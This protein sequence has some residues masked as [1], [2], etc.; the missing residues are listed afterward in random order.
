MVYHLLDRVTKALEEKEVVLRE[1]LSPDMDP[2]HFS[3]PAQT[4]TS[5]FDLILSSSCKGKVFL[6]LT[7]WGL[8]L[9]QFSA[10]P[11]R[12]SKPQPPWTLP[13]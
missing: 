8:E 6:Y 2:I 7:P 10:V 11:G 13:I 4:L 3:R 12:S 5:V 9:T 1:G